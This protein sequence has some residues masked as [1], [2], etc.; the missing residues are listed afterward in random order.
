MLAGL[1][2]VDA[3]RILIDDRDVTHLPSRERD[4]AMVFQSYALYPQ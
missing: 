3:G 2:A 4:I 1:E